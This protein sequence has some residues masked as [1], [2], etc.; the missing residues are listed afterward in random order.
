MSNNKLVIATWNKGG[1]WRK[2]LKAKK[3][4]L[5]GLL[6]DHNI[7]VLVVTEANVMVNDKLE[8]KN[9]DIILS[10]EPNSRIVI[11]VKTSLKAELLK[12][13]T[14]T[15]AI[16]IKLHNN[17]REITVIGTYRE[18]KKFGEPV[19]TIRKESEYWEEFLDTME[20][21]NDYNLIWAGDFNL[22]WNRLNDNQ[23]ERT[24]EEDTWQ[25]NYSTSRIDYILSRGLRKK[26][27]KTIDTTSD[28]K[29]IITN[30]HWIERKP[31]E[32]VIMRCWKGFTKEKL[33]KEAG[34]YKWRE[35]TVPA[36]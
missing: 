20:N 22:D 17:Y 31:A 27:T 6:N 34:K 10:N 32:P 12:S 23:Y 14:R 30:Y 25:R 18:H 9:Y 33:L 15:P 16:M 36:T 19:R 5:E 2:K 8:V 13:W 3:V 4:E 7:D 29:A 11:I 1:D 35:I 28:H 24:V 21:P 26:S